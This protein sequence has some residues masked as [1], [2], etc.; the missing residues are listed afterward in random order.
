[1]LKKV[2]VTDVADS[3]KKQLSAKLLFDIFD[4]KH[5]IT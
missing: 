3:L 5:E 2:E 1:M 4:T